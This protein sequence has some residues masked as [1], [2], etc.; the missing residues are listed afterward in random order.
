M[1]DGTDRVDPAAG[2]M[3]SP[4]ERREVSR[5]RSL[6]FVPGSRPEWQRKALACPAD[7]LVLDLE[8]AVAGEEKSS[9]REIVRRFI[10]ESG[11]DRVLF[12]RI[13]ELSGPDALDDLRAVV[14]P[15]LTGVMVPKIDSVFDVQLVDRLLT[16]LEQERGL[17]LGSI[18][19]IPVL[20]T[21]RALRLTY[22]LAA[23]SQRTA[24]MGAACGRG[25]D[26][27]RAL[28]FRWTAVGTESLSYR[29]RALV[30]IRAAGAKHPM[31]GVWTS[32]ADQDGLRAFAEQTRDL[33]YEGMV[34]IHPSQVPIINDVFTPS[35]EDL[36]FYQ[37]LV[38]AMEGSVNEGQGA[39]AYR[40]HM[41][42]V[43]MA[44]T[45]RERLADARRWSKGGAE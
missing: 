41:V 17:P 6:L 25:G 37:G 35:Q 29:S 3:G 18:V 39:V 19:V 16:W 45:A 43:A 8:D 4:I 11:R 2:S 38:E 20:E 24:Y 5:L 34:A 10:V 28:G 27:E 26:V 1:F 12:V 14:H 33:G 42:D 32:I 7:G 21:A 9:A 40:G 31:L 44:K 36:D 13:N 22:D 30:D 23:A 15:H